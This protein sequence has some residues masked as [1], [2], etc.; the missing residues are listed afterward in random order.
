MHVL[1]LSCKVNSTC[2]VNCSATFL[3]V[4][5]GKRFDQER[6]YNSFT[7]KRTPIELQL[8]FFLCVTDYSDF[9]T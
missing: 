3:Y 1:V 6:L 9:E 7:K 8:E 4:L 5:P 2:F